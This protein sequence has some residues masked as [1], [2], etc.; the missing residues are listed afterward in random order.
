MGR[1]EYGRSGGCKD[2]MVGEGSGG[3]GEG[4]TLAVAQEV[5]E[6]RVDIQI[7]DA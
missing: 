5:Q 3:E 1:H 7:H 4:I 2:M 6:Q